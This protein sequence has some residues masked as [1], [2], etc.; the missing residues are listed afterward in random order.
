MEW[1]RNL[2]DRLKGAR[3]EQNREEAEQAEQD[4]LSGKDFEGR[5]DDVRVAEYFPGTEDDY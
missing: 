5:K 1:L 4:A 3:A 2:I